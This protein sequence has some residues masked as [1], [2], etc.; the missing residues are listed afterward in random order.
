LGDLFELDAGTQT[1]VLLNHPR[2]AQHVLVDR[3]HNYVKQ[4]SFWSSVR[5]LIGLGLPTIEGDVWRTRRRMMNPQFRRA[6]IHELGQ[7]MAKTL[8]EQLEL[9]PADGS[10]VDIA[11][12]VS[13]ATMAVIVRT[14]FGTGMSAS[15]AD[16]VTGALAFSLDHM[17]QKVVTDV[18]PSWVPIPGRQAHERAV[19][20]IDDVLF[21]LIEQ[22]RKEPSDGGDLLNL[23]LQMRD[24]SNGGLSDQ[25]L[26][27][28]AMSLFLAGYET[29]ASSVSWGIGRMAHQP[30]LRAYVSDEVHRVLGSRQPTPDDV[31][32]LEAT[33]RF[34][35]EALRLHGPVFFLPRVA[36]ENDVIDGHPIPAGSMVSLMIDQIHR[37]PSAWDAPDVF[38]PDRFLPER[39]DGR[40]PTSWIPFGAGHRQCIGKSFATME[41]VLLLAMV[42]QRFR[43]EPSR[44]G[45]PAEQLGITRRPKGGVTLKLSRP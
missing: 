39:S 9:W 4:G 35:N 19:A 25:E 26:R 33:T 16:Q 31:P 28:E 10:E 5:S 3:A 24:D 38:D 13:R 1:V 42:V 12:L 32:A 8:D 23:M 44:D 30:E 36:V 34:F 17:L 20:Q 43:F 21:R 11:K 41:G 27:D 22:R 37:H 14:M 18:L 29:T 7:Q 40:P 2:H 6:R 15:E 45:L